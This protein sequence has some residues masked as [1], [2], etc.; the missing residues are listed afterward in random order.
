M[1][2]IVTVAAFGVTMTRMTR[3]GARMVQGRKGNNVNSVA[4]ARIQRGRRRKNW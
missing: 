4:M 3:M 2:K 1:E